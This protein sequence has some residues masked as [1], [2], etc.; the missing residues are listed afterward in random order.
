M[1]QA[2]EPGLGARRPGRRHLGLQYD[3][4][5]HG[6]GGRAGQEEDLYRDGR[7]AFYAK[8]MIKGE[9][10]LTAAYDSTR[11]P[12][13]R[14]SLYQIVDPNKYYLLYGDG[15]EQLHDAASEKH[16][17]VKL[18]RDQ[19]YALFGDFSTGLD[20]DRAFPLQPQPD[21]LQVRVQGRPR[22]STTCSS[23]DTDQAHLRDELQGDGTSGLYH[24]SRR[25]IVMNTEQRDHRDARPVP[26]RGDREAAA[27]VAE[28]G[29]HH[30]LRVGHDLLQIA[31][32]EPGRELQSRSSSWSST[33]PS[34]PATLRYTYGGRAAVK[35]LRQPGPG[36]RDPGAR[37]HTRRRR[38]PDRRGRLR[39]CNAD[40]EG[41]G[42]GGLDQERS[43][44]GTGTNGSAYLA[45]VQHRSETLDGTCLCA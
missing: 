45:E 1:A 9:W 13:G 39:G 5:Q 38:Q 34:T 30:R 11:P 15:A 26:Q 21:R 23:A 41:Q 20:G 4:G 17:Y 32:A 35:L 37:R 22:M 18:E 14:K 19:F 2:R 16:I 24:L 43:W 44:R 6:N 8:G 3:Q 28:P 7:V 33:R 10:L 42:R 40:D 12:D 36:R 29:L 27:A 25:N 31:G